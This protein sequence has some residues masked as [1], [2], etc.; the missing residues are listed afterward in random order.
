MK[1]H[2]IASNKMPSKSACN[3][4]FN[5]LCNLQ[6]ISKLQTASEKRPFLVQEERL[7][8][9]RRACSRTLK[10]LF[11]LQVNALS[12]WRGE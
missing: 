3:I 10:G 8:H 2:D 5:L 1:N 7:Q 6:Q 12:E 4:F 9:A 11:L